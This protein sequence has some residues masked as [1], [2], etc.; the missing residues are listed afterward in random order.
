[1]NR[2]PTTVSPGRPTASQQAALLTLLGDEDPVVY[3]TVRRTIMACGPDAGEW[4]RPQTLSD[5]PVLRRRTREIIRHF[6]RQAADI[7]FLSF[8]LKHGEEFDLEAGAW[9]LAATAYP[10]INVEA[11]Q[12]LLDQFAAELRERIDFNAGSG[13][14]LAVINQYLFE[15]LGFTGN[16]RHYHDPENSYLNRVLD[17]RTGSPINLCLLYLLLGRRLRLPLAGIGLPGHFI[18]RYQSSSDEV[19]LDVF[20]RGRLLTKADC[21]QHLVQGHHGLREDFLSPVSARRLLLRICGNLQQIHLQ[22]EQAED[23]T[24]V[25]RYVVALAG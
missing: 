7:R 1:M 21:I 23:A 14:I 3:Q 2:P 12:A 13:Q 25:Q 5:D 10:D 16:P 4:L 19:F 22:L 20:H 9:L 17:R 6:G 11:Y 15:E 24:R 8:C 18:C